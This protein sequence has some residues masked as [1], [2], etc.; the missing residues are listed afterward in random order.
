MRA[1]DRGGERLEPLGD[2]ADDEDLSA[3][4]LGSVRLDGQC[5]HE[6]TRLQEQPILS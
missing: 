1:P 2:L 4:L 6:K 5:A 3:E